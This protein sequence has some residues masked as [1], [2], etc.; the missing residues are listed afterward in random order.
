MIYLSSKYG[1]IA[2]SY[3]ALDM[4][5]KHVSSV[6]DCLEQTA[7]KEM[8][9]IEGK[10]S[11]QQK[12]ELKERAILMVLDAIDSNLRKVLEGLYSNLRKVI[13]TKIE[14]KCLQNKIQ[15]KES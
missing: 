9:K 11:G 12:S 7:K 15:K 6:V 3:L 8:I 14:A 10:L 13:V 5:D 1:N 2:L 4:L